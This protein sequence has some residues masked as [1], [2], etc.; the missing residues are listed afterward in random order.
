[1]YKKILAISILS[2]FSSLSIASDSKEISNVFSTPLRSESVFN[3]DSALRESANILPAQEAFQPNISSKNNKLIVNFNIQNGY[4]IYKN[5]FELKINGQKIDNGNIDYPINSLEKNDDIFGKVSVYEYNSTFTTNLDNSP[6]YNIE[7]SYQGCSEAYNIC[8]PKEKIIKNITNLNYLETKESKTTNNIKLTTND[9][10]EIKSII[11]DKSF[12]ITTITF[13]GIGLLLCLSP[14]VFPT[15]PLI[16]GLVIGSN[17]KPLLVSSIYGLGFVF[18]YAMIGLIIDLF[19]INL[20][21][22]IQNPIFIISSGIL[23]I[24]LGALTL[25]SDGSF[26][27]QN[28]NSKIDSAIRKINN[29]NLLTTF[30]I[31][32]LSSLILSPCAVAPLG[33][34]LIFISQKSQLFYGMWL[35]SILALGMIAPMVL[36]ATVLK[37][38]MPKTGEWLYDAR[39]IL[40]FL[41]FGFS[42]YTF[43]RY[44]Q[45]VLFNY[46]MIFIMIT[47][48]ISINNKIL[49]IIVLGLS[50]FIFN[51]FNPNIFLSKESNNEYN[52]QHENLSSYFLHVSNMNELNGIIHNAEAENKEVIVYVGADWCIACREME[53]TSFADI[54]VI[55]YYKK[56]KEEEKNKIF[57]KVDISELTDEKKEIL[58]MYNLQIAPYFVIYN[59]DNNKKLNI[60][61]ISIGYL[62]SSGLKKIL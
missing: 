14:C 20:Q 2:L 21:V 59:Q 47:L 19:S 58:T 35:L 48:L 50:L 28:L 26:G 49:R 10:S 46:L 34:T 18:S 41:L 5:K 3:S 27:T 12:I 53:K 40:G 36:M 60:S 39:K 31:G 43:S 32:F 9:S 13:F 33:A 38:L 55:N 6:N 51:I 8:Y 1:M 37:K 16:S 7:M 15:L 62:E 44:I 30:I 57:V 61:K 23:F 29:K 17:K 22:A 52:I 45:P 24:I 4:Y 42:L 54:D 56:Q 11:E 25:F